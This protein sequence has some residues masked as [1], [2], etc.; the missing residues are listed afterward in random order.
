LGKFDLYKVDLKGMQAGV[1]KYEYM[2]D[3]QFFIN[4]NGEDVNKG[5]VKVTLTVTEHKDFF[6]FSFVL[7]GVV[8]IP[9]DRCLDDMDFPIETTA[10]LVVKFGNDYSEENDEIVII[11]ESEGIINLAWFLYEFVVLTLPIKHVHTLGKCNKQM[12]S[13]LKKHS[14][15]SED[16][17]DDSFDLG[18]DDIIITDDDDSDEK[19]T[20]P[21]WDALKGFKEEE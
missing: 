10:H 21:R 5:R 13:K 14:A 7:S 17:E 4:I 18:M 11:P 9:C 12:T 3:N 8:V 16:N 15:K 1:Q 6:D 19:G 2:L 20:D